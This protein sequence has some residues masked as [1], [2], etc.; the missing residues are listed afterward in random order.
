MADPR[1]VRAAWL[2]LGRQLAARR[3]AAGLSQE[4]LGERTQYSRS[5][6]GNIETGLQH[7]NRTFWEKVD[8]LLSAGGDLLCGYD[9]AEALQ[10][11]LQRPVND[12]SPNRRVDLA[13]KARDTSALPVAVNWS[14][15]STLAPVAG[16]DHMVNVDHYLW[17]PPGRALPGVAIP[18]QLFPA[19]LG[20]QVVTHVPAAYAHDPFVQHP[21]RALVVG[22]TDGPELAHSCWTAGMPADACAA[23][24]RTPD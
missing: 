10:R 20:E 17:A 15:G 12:S 22:Q 14:R 5:S 11:T 7:V 18:A 19:V 21:R 6:I 2:D 1:S 3:R 23:R 24:P 4:T 9:A 8:E 13:I 16:G